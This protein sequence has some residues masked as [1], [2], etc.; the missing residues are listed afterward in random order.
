MGKLAERAA[1]VSSSDQRQ[2]VDRLRAERRKLGARL[3]RIDA[4]LAKLQSPSNEER[5]PSGEQLD[6]WFDS[7]SAGMPELDPLPADFSRADLYDDHD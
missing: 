5:A 3:Q 7:L 2:R 4:E 1:A 6:R